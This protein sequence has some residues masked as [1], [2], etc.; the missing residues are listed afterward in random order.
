M[1]EEHIGKQ[2]NQLVQRI[3]HESSHE[4]NGSREKRNQHNTKLRRL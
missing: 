1:K 3:S 2:P 4:P